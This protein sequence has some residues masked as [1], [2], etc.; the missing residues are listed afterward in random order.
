ML[1]VEDV[2]SEHV[3]RRILQYALPHAVVSNVVHCGGFGQIKARFDR[4]LNACN[5][6]PHVVL[7]DLDL[8]ECPMKLM[9]DWGIPRPLPARLIF[10]VAVREVEAWL[11]AD[12]QRMAEFLQVALAKVPTDVE[13]EIDPKRSLINLA[14]RS[15][16]K[17]FSLEFCPAVDSKASQGV[18]YND[19][20]IRFV[21]EMWR[22]DVARESSS[23]LNRAIGRLQEWQVVD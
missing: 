18:L 21:N 17:R 19:H 9:Q 15:R 16:S 2:A 3:L 6:V 14:R 12:R 13:G 1:V 5:V 20:L 11:L 22:V 23:S 8:H 4:Y 10:R 7:T